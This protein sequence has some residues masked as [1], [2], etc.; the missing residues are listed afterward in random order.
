ME[1]HVANEAAIV[2]FLHLHKIRWPTITLT[3][4]SLGYTLT[5]LR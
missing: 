3:L 5:I 2:L 1:S 4:C